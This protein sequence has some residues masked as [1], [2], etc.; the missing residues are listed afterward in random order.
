MEGKDEAFYFV[1]DLILRLQTELPKNAM[2][3]I[4][5]DNGIE[6][7]NTQFETFCA[8]LCL[9]HKFYSPYVPQQNG[10][11]ERKNRTLVEMARMMLD[12]HMTPRRYWAKAIN[13]TCFVS[14]HIFLRAFMKRTSYEL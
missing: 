5:S 8:S 3:D 12:Q 9:E 10:V 1:R 11:V 13:T 7:K 6:F 14:N 4:H 2:R